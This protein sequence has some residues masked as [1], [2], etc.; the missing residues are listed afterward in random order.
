MNNPFAPRANPDGTVKPETYEEFRERVLACLE[1][2]DTMDR[3]ERAERHIWIGKHHVHVGGGYWER[4]ETSAVMQE[5]RSSYVSGNF[6]ATLVLAL[7]YSEHVIIDALTLPPKKRTPTLADAIK[8]AREADLFPGDLLDGAAKLS[9]FR[10]PYIHRRDSDDKNTM[11]QR[12]QNRKSH[13]V[14]ILEQD[15]RDALLVM[16]GF[17]RHSFVPPL[18]PSGGT[19][20]ECQ[21]SE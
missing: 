9:Q 4:T 19:S 14:T 21:V 18:K 16:Y 3:P 8:L 17:F 15:A 12:V 5:A 13:P 7:A 11:G 20:P 1:E 2:L 6:I 10:N